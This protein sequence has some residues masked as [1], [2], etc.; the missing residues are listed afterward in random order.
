M[1]VDNIITLMLTTTCAECDS[2]QRI[3]DSSPDIP[4]IKGLLQNVPDLKI[5]SEH[6]M[7]SARMKVLQDVLSILPTC[8]DLI[9]VCSTNAAITQEL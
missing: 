5:D 3:R 2:T 1:G 8:L 7:Q 4:I 6:M 9:W